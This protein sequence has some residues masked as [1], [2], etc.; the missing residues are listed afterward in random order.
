MR[1]FLTTLALAALA[2]SP[3]MAK[4]VSTMAPASSNS[5]DSQGYFVP[6]VGYYSILRNEG[7]TQFGVEYRA[8]VWDFGVRPTIGVNVNT[9]GD[10]YGYAGINWDVALV[11]NQVYLIPNFMVG[12]YHN[13]SGHDLGGAIEFRSGIELAYQFQNTSRLGIAFNHISNASIYD[14]NPGAETLLVN[15]A[16]PMSSLFGGR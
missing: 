4:S 10:A 13:G 11:K 9:D 15:Y 3:V 7:S 12:A 14:H 1:I 2:V 5:V 16:I 6:Y 8:P